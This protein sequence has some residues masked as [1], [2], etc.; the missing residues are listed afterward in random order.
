M[1]LRM[2]NWYIIGFLG[3]SPSLYGDSSLAILWDF[4]EPKRVILATWR[5]SVRFW[6]SNQACTMDARPTIFAMPFPNEIERTRRVSWRAIFKH[7]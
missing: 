2:Y 5:I 4:F 3:M 1:A 6:G 7:F